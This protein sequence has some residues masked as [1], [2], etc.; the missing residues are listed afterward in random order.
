MSDFLVVRGIDRVAARAVLNA[1]AA[2]RRWV[3]SA[4][5]RDT[6]EREELFINGCDAGKYVRGKH[7]A[8]L[9]ELVVRLGDA[10][11]RVVHVMF[12]RRHQER[13]EQD[14]GAWAHDVI[15]GNGNGGPQ[16]CG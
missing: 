7:A 2:E 6:T 12:R 11:G 8:E 5:T 3:K 13:I 15:R 10:G 14:L 16:P 9:A 1:W 4:E